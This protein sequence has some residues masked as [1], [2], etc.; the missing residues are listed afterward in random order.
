MAGADQQVSKRR[1]MGQRQEIMQRHP[2]RGREA[3]GEIPVGTLYKLAT[4][5]PV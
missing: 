4:A 2:F 3:A 5:P 1:A